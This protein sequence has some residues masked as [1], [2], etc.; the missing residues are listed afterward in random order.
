M[1]KDAVAAAQE[2]RLHTRVPCPRCGG[3]KEIAEHLECPYCVGKAG[4]IVKGEHEEFCDYHAGQDPVA[5]GFPSVEERQR[6][7]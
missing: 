1:D 7:E 5:F 6:Y 2:K 4:D 3:I